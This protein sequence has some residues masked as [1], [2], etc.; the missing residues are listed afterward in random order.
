[1]NS[2]A[3]SFIASEDQIFVGK[4]KDSFQIAKGFSST[5]QKEK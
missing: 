5:R 1:M 3:S 2:E 4:L